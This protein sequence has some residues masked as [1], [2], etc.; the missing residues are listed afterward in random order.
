MGD[1]RVIDGDPLTDIERLQNHDSL[2]A[3]VTDGHLH[4]APAT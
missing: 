1:A 4:E 3:I 2:L